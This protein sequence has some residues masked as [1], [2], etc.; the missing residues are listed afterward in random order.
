[1]DP[2]LYPHVVRA[3]LERPWAILPSTLAT[4]VDIVRMRADGGRLTPADIQARLEA[5]RSEQGP[6]NGRQRGNVAVI[7]V[8]GV[9]SPRANL[10]SQTSGGTSVES[11]RSMFREALADND[12]DAIV[13]DVD[14][15]G[16]QVDGIPELAAEIRSARGQKPI[17]ANANT[18]AA[19]AAYWL[20][21]QA[22]EVSITPSG[23]V[24]SIGV[25][26]A[27]VDQSE[28][29]RMEGIKTTFV[30]QG[31]RKVEGNAH[32]PLGEE[33]R[34]AIQTDVDAFY[35]MFVRDVAR[36]RRTASDNVRSDAWGAGA[37][38]MAEPA[39]A[40]GMVDRI[41][42]LEETVRR[43]GRLAVQQARSAAAAG[44]WEPGAAAMI[45]EAVEQ[46]RDDAP[47]DD[48]PDGDSIDPDADTAPALVSG[49]ALADRLALVSE[50]LDATVT[51]LREHV[52]MRTREGRS[53][54]QATRDRIERLLALRPAMDEIEAMVR[55]ETPV[56]TAPAPM[57]RDLPLLLFEEAARGGYSVN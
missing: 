25:V 36:G 44:L 46:T 27:H 11:L 56:A 30:Y 48:V 35:S 45:A 20:A 38:V 23:V 3:V 15:P 51:H 55:S 2:S 37:T 8:Y 39:L 41:E 33:A 19:S 29:D 32:E 40:S 42:T 14:S 10:M 7:P 49:P 22:D 52:A 34:A 28:A 31:K 54:S 21:S 16:G 13:L 53:L 24:G 43:A 47:L 1:M 57:R 50:Q 18:M 9:L 17:L 12:V 6:R 26:A 5:A 4:I